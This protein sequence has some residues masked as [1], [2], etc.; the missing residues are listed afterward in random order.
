MGTTVRALRAVDFS[1]LRQAHPSAA[2]LMAQPLLA[3]SAA[4]TLSAE[5]SESKGKSF[6]GKSDA[7]LACCEMLA[8]VSG[9]SPAGA[10]WAMSV[11]SVCCMPRQA[12]RR[13][14]ARVT[15]RCRLAAWSFCANR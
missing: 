8:H 11:L 7:A 4:R 12:E 2:A 3:E 15:S 10:E 9:E 6:K 5:L 1:A 14:C 13:P